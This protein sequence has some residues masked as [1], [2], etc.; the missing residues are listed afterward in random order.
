VARLLVVV[1]ILLAGCRDT[2]GP[3]STATPRLGSL[4]EQLKQEGDQLL[5]EGR[6]EEAAVKYQRAVNQEP[7]D[8]ALRYALGVAFSHLQRRQDTVEQFRWVVE[9]GRPESPYVHLARTWLIES[10]ERVSP[11]APPPS[12]PTVQDD[13]EPRGTI[14]G[15]SEWAGHDPK[16]R[17]VALRIVLTPLQGQELGTRG[18]R[19]FR[20]GEP[21]AFRDIPVGKYQLAASSSDAELWNEE[22]TVTPDKE[23]VVHLSNANSPVPSDHPLKDD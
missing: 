5:A 6:Y 19:R 11:P 18:N 1:A 17:V 10:G 4:T 2:Q 22:V 9:R 8:P 13:A 20:L 21:F 23:T 14:R 15:T 16:R 12:A 7:G 3:A